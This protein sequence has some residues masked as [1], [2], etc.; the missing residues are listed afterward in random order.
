MRTECFDARV[1]SD[2]SA[3]SDEAQRVVKQLGCN[4]TIP[5]HVCSEDPRIRPSIEGFSLIGTCMARRSLEL[6]SLVF[7]CISTARKVVNECFAIRENALSTPALGHIGD[8]SSAMRPNEGTQLWAVLS[9]ISSVCRF[10]ADIKAAV[11][12]LRCEVATVV[13]DEDFWREANA[14]HDVLHPLMLLCTLT[15]CGHPSSSQFLLSWLIAIGSVR[16]HSQVLG[17]ADCE[18]FLQR[19]IAWLSGHCEPLAVACLLLDPR[20]RG[21]GLSSYG[22]SRAQSFIAEIFTQMRPS[23]QPERVLEQLTKFLVHQPPF[24]EDSSWHIVASMPRLFWIEFMSDTPDLAA[25]ATT[26][27]GYRP[28][29]H[30][31]EDAWR[32]QF[33][34]ATPNSLSTAT[35]LE[36]EKFR[37]HRQLVVQQSEEYRK[38]WLILRAP[39]MSPFIRP[40]DSPAL[41]NEAAEPR[42]QRMQSLHPEAQRFIEQIGSFVD[43]ERD[44][45]MRTSTS[46]FS[47]EANTLAQLR[48]C[49]HLMASSHS[50][51]ARPN[52]VCAHI[53][54]ENDDMT[55]P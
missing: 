27:M 48:A 16:E 28:Y 36:C 29:A 25:L 45:E 13:G 26:L 1:L 40:I 17:A 44:S 47:V 7:G 4:T 14:L 55:A 5:V 6:L 15:I 49:L 20:C 19:A 41:L 37:A 24:D 43:Q 22:R 11:Q 31:I 34:A 12:S 50:T 35:D 2:Q 32:S 9:A 42:R 10:E 3:L 33:D 54:T 38:K 23:E 39:L 30:A 18:E 8:V 21:L 51:D 53:D 46:F 52:P